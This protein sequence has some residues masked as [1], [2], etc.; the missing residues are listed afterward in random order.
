MNAIKYL[1]DPEKRAIAIP[2][3]VPLTLI[4]AGWFTV[5][6]GFGWT[7]AGVAVA[8][9]LLG[10]RHAFDADHIASIDNVV[11][12]LAEERK[13]SHSVGLFFSLG[14]S[15]IVMGFMLLIGV[16]GASFYQQYN[17]E[18]GTITAVATVFVAGFL[19]LI[20]IVNFVSLVTKPKD[21]NPT[22]FLHLLFPKLMNAISRQKDMYLVGFIF[23]LGL[24]TAFGLLLIAS[25]S[26]SLYASLSVPLWLLT[27][28]L[29]L[30]FAG[31]MAFGDSLGTYFANRAYV[32]SGL[33]KPGWGERYRKNVTLLVAT[34]ATLVAVPIWFNLFGGINIS[35]TGLEYLGFALVG[36]SVIS[37]ILY[38]KTVSRKIA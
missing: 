28:S 19:S 30:L 3:A 7:A 20:A 14:H 8:A 23:G 13:D 6:I 2:F 31:S 4:F 34:A 18:I 25:A 32:P 22:G 35:I 10:A 1:R 36:L 27:V 26:I 33:P 24:D 16:V 29:G 9:M 38:K 5:L 11:R 37:V 21:S 15:T 17:S 12:K